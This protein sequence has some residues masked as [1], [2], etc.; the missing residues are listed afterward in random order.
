MLL[1]A[2]AHTAGSGPA[3]CLGYLLASFAAGCSA[4]VYAEFVSRAPAAGGAY[5]FVYGELGELCGWMTGWLLLLDYAVGAAAIARGWSDY[6]INFL[7][8]FWGAG[9]L[10]TVFYPINISNGLGFSLPTLLLLLALGTIVA[11]GIRAASTTSTIVTVT[12]IS[13]ALLAVVVAFCY[14]NPGKTWF[15]GSHESTVEDGP[16]KCFR[17]FHVIKLFRHCKRL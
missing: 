6:F 8:L 7:E 14:A 11:S 5:I 10:P 1:G 2:A 13:A 3:L 16:Y 12:K 4:L 9:G 15:S 17:R